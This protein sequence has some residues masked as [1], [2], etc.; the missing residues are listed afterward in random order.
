MRRFSDAD[1]TTIRRIVEQDKYGFELKDIISVAVPDGWYVKVIEDKVATGNGPYK[2]FRT[3]VDLEKARHKSETLLVSLFNLNEIF[4]YLQRENL[5]KNVGAALFTEIE[6]NKEDVA[7]K[8]HLGMI[9]TDQPKYDLYMK[10]FYRYQYTSEL[11]QLVQD[12][13]VSFEEKLAKKNTKI[14]MWS[15]IAAAIAAACA[16]ISVF[17]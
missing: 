8:S 10:F 11:S 15:F 6:I 9:L 2:Q 13:F 4:E 17:T 12:D 7:D 5:I 16:L 14:A 1:K 3:F